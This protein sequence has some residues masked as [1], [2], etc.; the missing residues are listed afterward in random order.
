METSHDPGFLDN[1][2][3][4][5]TALANVAELATPTRNKVKIG[6]VGWDGY[7]VHASTPAGGTGPPPR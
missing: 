6:S 4:G 3:G 5:G 1:R 7:R 2:Q